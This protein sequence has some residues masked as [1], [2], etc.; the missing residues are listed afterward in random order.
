MIASA[1]YPVD[2]LRSRSFTCR[3]GT[4]PSIMDYARNN[5]VA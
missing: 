5:Y 1:F 4:T 3:F 2:S